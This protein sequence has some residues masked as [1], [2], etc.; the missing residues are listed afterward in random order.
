MIKIHKTV[1][2]KSE[3]NY[4]QDKNKI[5]SDEHKIKFNYEF[6]KNHMFESRK[7]FRIR[8]NYYNKDI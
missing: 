8:N 2:K 3:Q 1:M 6:N 4:Q 7:S 5:K